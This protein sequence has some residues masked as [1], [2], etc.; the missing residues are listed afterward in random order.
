MKSKRGEII[1]VDMDGVLADYTQG[2]LDSMGL[3]YPEMIRLPYEAHVE[4]DTHKVYP[5]ELHEQIRELTYRK[6]FFAGL[7]PIEGALEG[8]QWLTEEGYD[9]RIC[10]SPLRRWQHCVAEKYEW[11]AAYLGSGFVERMI[12]TRDKSLV[13][14]AYLIDDRPNPAEHAVVSPPWI[15]LLYDQPYNRNVTGIQRVTWRE[16]I[17]TG[18]VHNIKEE[19]AEQ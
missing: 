17:R 5:T 13:W 8:I 18:I 10:T 4:F 6:G 9:I 15:H 2:V 12:L 19:R 14:G 7:K 1:L 16:L 11:V 3:H